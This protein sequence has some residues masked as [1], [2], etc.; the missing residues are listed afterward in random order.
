MIGK[1]LNL[2]NGDG[3][4]VV[5][6]GLQRCGSPTACVVC[7]ARIAQSRCETLGTIFD[8]YLGRGYRMMMLTLTVRHHKGQRLNHLLDAMNGA[9]E[10]LQG[11]G[12]F[13]KLRKEN[14]LKIVRVLEVTWGANGWH[15]HFHIMMIFQGDVPTMQVE[16][17]QIEALWIK[18]V[19]ADVADREYT[20]KVKGK[21]V[22]KIKKGYKGLTA[23]KKGVA[24]DFREDPTP[25]MRAWYLTK[26]SGMS[27]LEMT[28][29]RSKKSMDG[30]LGV[31]QVHSKAVAGDGEAL[32]VWQEYE[33]AIKRRRTFLP[34]RDL[35][36]FVGQKWKDLSDD[37]EEENLSIERIADNLHY[38]N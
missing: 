32:K 4:N 15:P 12:A 13:K 17:E 16:K 27:S 29:G 31:W 36:S 37:L 21:T 18:H 8:A 26:A 35:A 33:K 5:V 3:K 10:D 9:W 34:S 24:V 7:S 20:V 2:Y 30:N 25:K 28:M 19:T 23:P 11:S 22:K 14:G 6:S 1:Y 38:V